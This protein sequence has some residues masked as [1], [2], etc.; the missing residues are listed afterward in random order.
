M[1]SKVAYYL[2]ASQIIKQATTIGIWLLVCYPIVVFLKNSINTVKVKKLR[3][4][5]VVSD[6]IL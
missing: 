3:T 1:Q 2:Y 4:S 6:Y 5:L